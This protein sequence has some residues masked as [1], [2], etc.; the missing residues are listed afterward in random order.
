MLVAPSLHPLKAL[1]A[2]VYVTLSNASLS[3][4]VESKRGFEVSS[5]L[6]KIP[7]RGGVPRVNLRGLDNVS[8]NIPPTLSSC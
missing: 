7:P 5:A 3:T 8:V 6:V 4:I 2:Y 1:I